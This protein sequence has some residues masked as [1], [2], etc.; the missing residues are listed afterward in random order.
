VRGV[1]AIQA[2]GAVAVGLHVVVAAVDWRLVGRSTAHHVIGCRRRD[3][4]MAAVNYLPA[5]GV[6][7]PR[8]RY[9][10]LC[11]LPRRTVDIRRSSE[12]RTLRR[13]RRRRCEMQL[14][15]FKSPR[16]GTRRRHSIC[17]AR[18]RAEATAGARRTGRRWERR[19]LLTEVETRQRPTVQSLSTH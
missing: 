1:I 13:R 2:K 16:R 5:R 11:R 15:G 10:A 18:L 7:P 3:S 14:K 19:R 6:R 4:S 9:P 17:E 8:S 12:T